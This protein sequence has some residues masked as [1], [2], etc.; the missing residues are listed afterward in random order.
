MPELTFADVAAFIAELPRDAIAAERWYGGKGRSI[1]SI[2]LAEA[3]DLGD[4]SVL[5]VVD[6]TESGGGAR[7]RY[8]IP[9]KARG[10]VAVAEPGDGTW[11]ALAV[12]IAEGRT[13]G[14]LPRRTA[15][16]RAPAPVSA[17]L[18]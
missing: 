12:A 11:R 16:G 8:S 2:A 5:A 3:F 18:V 13:I 6:V 17:A 9:L 1:D 14:A 15:A 4:G 10:A 7:G